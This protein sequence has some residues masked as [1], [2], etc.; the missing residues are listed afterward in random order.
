MLT[1]IITL[2]TDFVS[3]ITGYIG[4]L[5]TDLSPYLTLILGILL[6]VLVI[7][8]LIGAIKK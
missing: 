8:I 3:S 4:I 2:P 5:I 7:D 1:T 6:A